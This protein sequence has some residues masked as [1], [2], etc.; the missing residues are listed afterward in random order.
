MTS[1]R[2]KLLWCLLSVILIVTTADAA[3][4]DKSQQLTK[5]T[6][7]YDTSKPE[8]VEGTV[9][10]FFEI[11]PP[12]SPS[13]GIHMIVKAEHESIDIH[14]GPAWYI[15]S[16]DNQI[17]IG[18]SIVSK[19]DRVKVVGVKFEGPLNPKYKLRGIRAAEVWKKEGLVFKLRDQNGKPLWSGY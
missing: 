10:Q 14:L 2:Y 13:L 11:T 1:I 16:S 17:A 3:P 4:W 12:K 18:S 5:M 8:T 19:G 15:I 9:E 7:A 6:E